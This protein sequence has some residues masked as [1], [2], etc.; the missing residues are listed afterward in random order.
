MITTK[1]KATPI[2]LSRLFRIGQ[3]ADKV[4][5]LKFVTLTEWIEKSIMK[6]QNG[7]KVTSK[8][9]FGLM[10]SELK[11]T[12]AEEPEEDSQVAMEL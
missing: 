4:L 10:I 12:I 7:R 3:E 6:R 5:W 2:Q 8:R 1:P 11:E 9:I